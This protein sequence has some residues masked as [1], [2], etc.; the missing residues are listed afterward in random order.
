MTVIGLHH[1]EMLT[2][3]PPQRL[4]KFWFV[5]VHKGESA[6]WKMENIMAGPNGCLSFKFQ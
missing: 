2:D 1:E 6:E 4:K 3:L 5:L